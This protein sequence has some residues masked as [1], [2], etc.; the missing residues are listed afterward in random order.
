MSVRK[1]ATM[2][3]LL[4]MAIFGLGLVLPASAQGDGVGVGPVVGGGGVSAPGGA[5]NYV[6]VTVGRRTLLEA[7]T[8]DEG[9]VQRTA[10]LRG[11]LGVPGAAFDGSGTGLSADGH[12]LVLIDIDYAYSQ[13][14]SH[15]VVVDARRMR[16]RESFWLPANYELDAISPDARWLYFLH[17]RY[18]RKGVTYEVRAYDLPAHRLLRKPI[19]DPR[20]PDE[21]MIGQPVTRTE[22]ADGRWVYTLYERQSGPPFIHALDTTGVAARCIDLPPRGFDGVGF[23]QISLVVAGPTLRIVAP[24]AHAVID[25]RTHALTRPAASR[26]R[27]DGAP[28]A[29]LLIAAPLLL[30][31]LGVLARRRRPPQAVAA[32]PRASKSSA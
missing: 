8:R 32:S 27:R 23:P 9:A 10:L 1:E 22:S 14:R 30:A 29:L 26:P 31:A 6:T 13:R 11:D 28:W 3:R 15:L 5:L 25:L 16:V 7:I 12:T 17:Y 21:K 4:A 19:V 24:R 20:E 2:R 18:T